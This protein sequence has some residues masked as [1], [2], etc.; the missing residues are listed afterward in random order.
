[1]LTG[2]LAL[3]G[4]QLSSSAICLWNPVVQD[5]FLEQMETIRILSVSSHL[6]LAFRCFLKMMFS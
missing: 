6:V 3:L 5:Q 4:D 1:M 2:V